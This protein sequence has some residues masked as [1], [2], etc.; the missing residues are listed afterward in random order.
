[1]QLS[2]RKITDKLNG[3]FSLF[4]L[5]LTVIVFALTYY[6][7]CELWYGIKSDLCIDN[8]NIR[9]CSTWNDLANSLTFILIGVSLFLIV[10]NPLT[11]HP[12]K[13]ILKAVILL[14]IFLTIAIITMFGTW[15]AGYINGVHFGWW[16]IM[17]LIDTTLITIGIIL[18]WTGKHSTQHGI[19]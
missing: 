6:T 7:L 14:P 11:Y 19:E 4:G 15:H 3:H 17:T 1:M 18:R 13:S 5:A 16:F 9:H 8:H 12:I 2:I 10:I